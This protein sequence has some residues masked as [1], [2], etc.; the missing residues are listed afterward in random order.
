MH[1]DRLPTNAIGRDAEDSGSDPKLFKLPN[2]GGGGEVSVNPVLNSKC[3]RRLNSHWLPQPFWTGLKCDSH[4]GKTALH[5]IP[6]TVLWIK[7]MSRT[8]NA[9]SFTSSAFSSKFSI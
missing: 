2:W 1:L 6:H 4:A 9:A 5:Y 7:I 3:A 8:I